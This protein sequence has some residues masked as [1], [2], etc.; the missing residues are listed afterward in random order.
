[1]AAEVTGPSSLCNVVAVG[2]LM[3]YGGGPF[4][5]ET[6]YLVTDEN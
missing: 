4:L 1:M 2:A 6:I 3:Y 5:L